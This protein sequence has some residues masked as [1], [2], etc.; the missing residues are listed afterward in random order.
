MSGIG[1]KK[2]GT[3]LHICSRR[4]RQTPKTLKYKVKPTWKHVSVTLDIL[5]S[6]FKIGDFSETRTKLT[7]IFY[8][9]MVRTLRLRYFL[10]SKKLDY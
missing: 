3:K 10:I 6:F 1:T 4:Y 8:F 5:E 7:L 2:R 9:N